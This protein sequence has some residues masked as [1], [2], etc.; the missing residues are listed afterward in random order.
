MFAEVVRETTQSWTEFF[1][2]RFL[3]TGCILLLV[4]SLFKL[5]ISSW[6]TFGCLYFSTKLSISSKLSICCC[7]IAVFSYLFP[8]TSPVNWNYSFFTS[9]FVYLGAISFLLGESGQRFVNFVYPFK[10]PALGFVGFV[11]FFNLYFLSTLIFIISLL[12]L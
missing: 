11:F 9:Y 5:F 1:L 10:E 8:P 12:W 4:I 6:F 2:G 7:I 3:I